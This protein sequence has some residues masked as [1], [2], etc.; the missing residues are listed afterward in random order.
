MSTK[1]VVIGGAGQAGKIHVANLI[2]LGA[3]VASF[4]VVDNA[5]ASKNFNAKE[6]AHADCVADGYKVAVVALPDHMLFPHCDKIL[7]A[8]FERIMVEKP[9]AL[10]SADLEKLAVKAEEKGIT[11]Y[12]NYQRSFDDRISQLL[13]QI[14]DMCASGYTL[15][16]VS[17]YSCDKSQPPQAAHQFLNQ[18]C[19]DYA[20]LLGVLEASGMKLKDL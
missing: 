6:A 18:G 5:Q 11:M 16:Y 10:N 20:L 3:D 8:G 13:G 7:D 19:H 1:V 12:I 9:G 17:V 2:S 15:D 14:R 4:D